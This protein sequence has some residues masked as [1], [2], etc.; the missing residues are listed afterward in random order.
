MAIDLRIHES[1]RGVD[2]ATWDSLDGV[3][4]TPFLSWAWLS[5]LEQTGCV[6]AEKGWI[7][8]HIT[9]W[10][11]PKLVGAAPAYL[12]DNSEGEF[13]FDYAWAAAAERAMIPYYPKLVVAVPFTPATAPRLLVADAGSRAALVPAFA[14]GLRAIVKKAKISSAHV[15]FPTEAEADAL[16]A[17]GMARRLGVQFHWTNEGYATF[18]DFLSRFSSKRRT[19]IRRE[20]REMDKLGVTITTARG[21]AITPEIVDAMYG[22]YT[23]TVD[24][25][26]WGRRY[27]NRAFFEEVTAR[28]PDGI[29]VVVARQGAGRIIAGA[30]N[31]AGDTALF[32]RYWGASVDLPFLHFNVCYYHSIDECITR[33]IARFEAGAGGSH[34]MARGFEPSLTQSAHHI[35]DPRLD[36]G[37]RSFLARERRVIEE[38]AR[39]AITTKAAW[40]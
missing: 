29:E 12:K 28:M 39:E 8:R 22:F 35:A 26:Y 38:Q 21:R 5:V 30:F 36:A 32:G 23:A 2:E 7:P 13:V 6:G 37:V 20:R 27:L 33:K 10:D 3:K 15:L 9:L 11:G 40:K 1:I 4:G 24:K 19:Q 16:E 18:D 31:L 25:F 14:E 17:A 34:K